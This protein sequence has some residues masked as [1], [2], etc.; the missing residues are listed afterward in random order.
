LLENLQIPKD[1]FSPAAPN[2]LESGDLKS[3]WRSDLARRS[4]RIRHASNNG[5]YAIDGESPAGADFKRCRP[6]P[7]GLREIYSAYDDELE[8]GAKDNS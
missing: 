3:A 8:Y 1:A 2:R 5:G 4:S 6:E 7:G